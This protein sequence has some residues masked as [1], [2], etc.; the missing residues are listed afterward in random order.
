MKL[1]NLKRLR[2]IHRYLSCFFSPL[3]ILF[4]CSGVILVLDLHKDSKD[5]SYKSNSLYYTLAKLH[6]KQRLPSKLSFDQPKSSLPLKYLVAIMGAGLAVSS[7]IGIGLGFAYTKHRVFMFG[8]IFLG[9][10]LPALLLYLGGG[11]G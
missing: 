8:V 2:L 9:A 10:L 11:S 7:V 6:E 1:G 5:A 4:A 3:I